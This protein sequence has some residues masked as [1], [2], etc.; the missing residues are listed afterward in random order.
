MNLLLLLLV[1]ISIYITMYIYNRY[2]NYTIQETT[3]I[4][5]KKHNSEQIN[6]IDDIY[7]NIYKYIN[8]KIDQKID[9]KIDEKVNEKINPKFNKNNEDINE[10]NNINKNICKPSDKLI[11]KYINLNKNSQYDIIQTL[12]N[13]YI[14]NLISD[15]GLNIKI[16]ESDN[17]N[18]IGTKNNIENNLKKKFTPKNKNFIDWYLMANL[19]CDDKDNFDLI[20]YDVNIDNMNNNVNSFDDNTYVKK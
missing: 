13:K 4:E 11:N 18:C 20:N 3:N 10:K 8:E 19:E 17:P 2:Y 12:Q 7:K 14:D 5:I 6:I 9:E 1:L 15:A 16:P